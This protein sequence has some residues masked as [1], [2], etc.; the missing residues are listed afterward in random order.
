MAKAKV[1]SPI[2][3]SHLSHI[4]TLYFSRQIRPPIYSLK[5]SKLRRRRVIRYSI[6]FF[7]LFVLF[8]ILVAGPAIV[9]KFMEVPPL[10]VF[11][12]QQPT[13]WNNNDTTME[14]TGIFYNGGGGN[15]AAASAD[16]GDAVK[17]AIFNYYTS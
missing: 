1:R 11:E 16:A 17:R 13:D 3:P 14:E 12:L 5:Q 7:S 9:V 15:N 8:L 4:L 6:L 10:D 2:I